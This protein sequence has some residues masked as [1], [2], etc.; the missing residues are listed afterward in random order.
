MSMNY[1][2]G[3][4]KP[5]TIPYDIAEIIG[6]VQSTATSVRGENGKHDD[7]AEI[8]VRRATLY[9]CMGDHRAAF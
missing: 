7:M 4:V 9:S 2:Q 5:V 3:S 6:T 8:F 1:A